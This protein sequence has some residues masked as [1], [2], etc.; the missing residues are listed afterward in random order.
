MKRR[1]SFIHD[2]KTV[3]ITMTS[4]IDDNYLK[5]ITPPKT[6]FLM[7]YFSTKEKSITQDEKIE[8]NKTNN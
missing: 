3:N 6:S 1:E 5:S 2:F 8:P 4:N 7:E